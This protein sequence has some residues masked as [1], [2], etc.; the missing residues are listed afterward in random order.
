MANT[1]RRLN[2]YVN[3]K[4]VENNIKSIGGAY[5]RLQ[6][7]VAKL[8]IGS[9]A[10]NEKVRDLRKLRG[11]LD[12]HRKGIR[13]IQKSWGGMQSAVKGLAA[14][15]AAAMATERIIAFG[16]EL[17][18]LNTEMDAMARKNAQVLGDQ[19]GYVTGEAERNAAAMGLTKGAYIDA[20]A[21]AADLLVPLG[22]TRQSASEMSV[23][24]T[25]LSGALSEWTGGQQ[26]ATQVSEVLRKAMLGEREGLK[27]LGISISEADVKQRLLREGKD[28]LTGSA[29]Q[30]AKAEAT[31]ALIMEKSS[32]AQEAYATNTDSA[33]RKQ[34]EM[35]ASMSEAKERLASSLAPAFSTMIGLAADFANGLA[36][37]ADSFYSFLNPAESA[38]E[39]YEAQS[40]AVEDLNTRMPNL[41]ARYNELKTQTNLN[42]DEQRELE[43]IMK[44]IGATVPQSVAAFDEYGNILGI[45]TEKVA[46]FSKQQEK[47]QE[48]MRN[49]AIETN[50]KKLK[51][52]RKEYESYEE[53]ILTGVMKDGIFRIE[54]DQSDLQKATELV[55]SVGNEIIET[56]KLLANLQN[57]ERA[58]EERAQQAARQ[59]QAEE[60][61]KRAMAQEQAELAAQEERE[62]EQKRIAK[63]A[64]ER[65]KAEQRELERKEK[66]LEKLRESLDKH[67]N[68]V[69]L[70]EL[71]E[72][73]QRLERIRQRYKKEI[74]Q[75]KELE[76]EKVEGVTEVRK[77]LERVMEEE[78]EAERLKIEQEKREKEEEKEAEVREK[79]AERM[80]ER[81]EH[82]LEIEEEIR[83]EAM[84][85]KDIELYELQQHYERLIKAAENYGIDTTE[86][87]KKY[88]AEQRKLEEDNAKTLLQL[89][90]QKR[91]SQSD[92]FY[93][94]ADTVV[95]GIDLVARTEEEAAV[96]KKAVTLAKIAYDTA[97]AISSV[98]AA[99][100]STSITPIDLAIKIATGVGTVLGNM[101]QAKALLSTPVPQRFYG[102][103]FDVT[104]ETDGRRYSANYLGRH[105]GGMLPSSPSLVLASEQGPEYF[106]PNH[107]LNN[108]VVADSVRII[109]NIRLGGSRTVQQYQ[110]GGST[111]ELE[112]LP[113]SRG[114]ADEMLIGVMTQLL[115]TLQGGI[116]TEISDD[117]LVRMME[118]YGEINS[119]AK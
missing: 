59:K 20:T 109:E 118:R 94:L 93:A 38:L 80:R 116:T 115:N 35:N 8:E 21:A 60:E 1:T 9:Q 50:T 57:P 62:R 89:E 24:I 77:E 37:L 34:N 10:Y 14:P 33:L 69:E 92:L 27:G 85:E 111:S 119:V 42:A 97:A 16:Q 78:L 99:A 81:A 102:G 48:Q 23:E 26:D 36:S 87:K 107:L 7:E 98:V 53:A 70:A 104:G 41:V 117:K 54:M 66:E 39:N 19:L 25:N 103:V 2:I 63:L 44:E 46:A 108:P 110:A 5:R 12:N 105:K 28:K 32:D 51:E 86:L 40:R 82:R 84:S 11:E 55:K 72:D 3:G 68:R 64:E 31:L 75:A 22:F 65:K 45:N 43:K 29:E 106:V 47:L 73:E 56:E 49:I 101:A 18:A 52:L 113:A 96:F 90:E 114:H 58:E 13:G 95:A 74:E 71:N 76:A 112:R 91:K 15:I 4:E 17:Y 83:L 88:L 67:Y 6:N 79:I 30:Q 61:A 100:S